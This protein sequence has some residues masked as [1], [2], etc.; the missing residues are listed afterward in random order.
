[1]TGPCGGGILRPP[2]DLW[3]SCGL[4][5]HMLHLQASRELDKA[6]HWCDHTDM[7]QHFVKVLPQLLSKVPT[8]EGPWGGLPRRLREPQSRAGQGATEAERGRESPSCMCSGQFAADKEKVTHLLQIPQYCNLHMY[9]TDG[10]DPVSKGSMALLPGAGW[11]HIPHSRVP[12]V[13]TVTPSHGG[14]GR[15]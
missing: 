4:R 5:L 10:L 6:H 3:V 1:M 15:E 7:S 8:G 9:G 11:G 12:G 2:S 13:G 14:S